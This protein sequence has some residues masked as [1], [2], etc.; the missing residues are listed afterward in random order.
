MMEKE[1]IRKRYTK[2]K[3]SR[4]R[5]KIEETVL[6]ACKLSDGD[7]AGKRVKWCGHPGCKRTYG[8]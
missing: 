3:I 2:P 6:L 7:P 8:S 1:K 5:M 4:V